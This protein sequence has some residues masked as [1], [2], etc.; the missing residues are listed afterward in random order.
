MLDLSSKGIT[1]TYYATQAR[2]VRYYE[3]MR[4]VYEIES[5]V[6]DLRRAATPENQQQP[7]QE[8][9]AN[10][11]KNPSKSDNRQDRTA[12]NQNYSRRTGQPSWLPTHGSER[13]SGMAASLIA[14]QARLNRR[15]V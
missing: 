4:L 6:R 7:Q 3:N 2:V 13:T 1:K 9:P 10:N 8:A 11:P 12:R 5:R 15:T 14:H